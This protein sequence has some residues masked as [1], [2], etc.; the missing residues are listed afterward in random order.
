MSILPLDRKSPNNKVD[1]VAYKENVR[2][3]AQR[4]RNL[5]WRVFPCHT[6]D[7][8]GHC[9]CG[10]PAC[11]DQGKHPRAEFAPHGLKDA[12]IDPAKIELWFGPAA[13][14]SNLAIVTGK[15]SGITV[16]DVD[17]K[18]GGNDTWTDLTRESGEPQTLSAITGSTGSHWLFKYNSAL[19]TRKDALGPGLDVRNDNNGYIIACP[20]RHKSGGEYSWYNWEDPPTLDDLPEHLT[21]PPQK[22]RGPKAKDDPYQRKYS[23]T[24]V[25]EMLSSIPAEDR[26]DWRHFGIILG[27]DSNCS[28]EAWD[29]Y[30]EWAGK[31]TG[32]AGRNHHQEMHNCF[33]V[34]SQKQVESQLSMGTIIKAALD[35]GWAP[36][37]G[38]SSI[39]N[40]CYSADLNKFLYKPTG[41]YWLEAA[42][43]A[44]VSK[45]NEDGKLIKASEWLK[46]HKM[47]TSITTDPNRKETF[48][49]GF[50]FNEDGEYVAVMGAA[51]YNNYRHPTIV[52]G[53][54]TKAKPFLHH[55]RR[56]FNKPGDADQYLDYMA[57][58]VQKP[59]TKIR[60]ALLIAGKQGVGKDTAIDF[61]CPAIGHSNV[62]NILPAAFDKDFNEYAAATLIRIS[63]VAN[64]QDMS[65]WAFN[66]RTKVLIAGSPDHMVI[67]PKYGQKFTCLL[68][69]GVLLTTNNLATGIFIPP[70]DRR[71]D[72]L[73]CATLK[74]MGLEDKAVRKRYFNA[75]WFWFVCRGGANHVAALLRE[76]DVS[77][78]SPG[79]GQRKTNAH[80]D[81][82]GNNTDHWLEDTLEELG[83]PNVLCAAWVLKKAEPAGKTEQQGR[84]ILGKEIGD[85]GYVSYR[86]PDRT[87]GRWP[88]FGGKKA[89]VYVK[90]DA[91]MTPQKI[92]DE[93]KALVV[94]T[95]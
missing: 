33:Y 15:L 85:L 8:N 67:N 71:Y 77:K 83:N 46:R 79:Q 57:H 47:V 44:A 81:V 22:K 82:V 74:E 11:T 54:P 30:V 28:Q 80:H 58:V 20:S 12:S 88:C 39:H 95:F 60:F 43:D 92:A 70:D 91:K 86:N 5:G 68:H 6:I 35:H 66:E 24:E 19:K 53:D 94:E 55:V 3:W 49:E 69:G 41:R 59:G 32:K 45:Q 51:V 16:I 17:P 10:N 1:W 48:I 90:A 84:L 27:R 62:A 40:F 4:C 21:K 76:R 64:A 73:D 38:K 37:T 52:S 26:D 23:I 65:K 63:E 89:T 61:C 7:D 14:A 25:R 18:N 78:F 9:S 31:W 87:D 56:I 13:P 2:Q 72:V 29:A 36:T 93:I 42:V 75:L 50:D 34:D